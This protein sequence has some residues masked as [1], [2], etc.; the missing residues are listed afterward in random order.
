MVSVNTNPSFVS[1]DKYLR[2]S[3]G[4][5]GVGFQSNTEILMTFFIFRLLYSYSPRII[6][7]R[8]ILKMFTK[9]TFQYKTSNFKILAETL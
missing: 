1:T 3:P 9:K 7:S 6:F 2:V 4:H 8:Q 5:L